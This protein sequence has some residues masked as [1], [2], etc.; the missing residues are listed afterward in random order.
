MNTQLAPGAVRN[1]PVHRQLP[2][3]KI[4]QQN[5]QQPATPATP[6]TGLALLSNRNDNN[7]TNVSKPSGPAA[8]AKPSANQAAAAAV[9]PP[10]PVEKPPPDPAEFEA[11]YEWEFLPDTADWLRLLGRIGSA[12]CPGGLPFRGRL[13]TIDQSP[14]PLVSDNKENVPPPSPSSSESPGGHHWDE[15]PTRS[16]CRRRKG[17][18]QSSLGSSDSLD[19]DVDEDRVAICFDIDRIL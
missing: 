13:A 6:R 3:A 9:H 19:N 11:P 17:Y 5:E 16:G 12:G 14:Q 18:R 7:S 1:T 8:A 2:R 10:P 15:S 4:F